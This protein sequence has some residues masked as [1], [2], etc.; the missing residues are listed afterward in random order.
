MGGVRFAY[1]YGYCGTAARLGLDSFGNEMLILAFIGL[2]ILDTM[3][4]LLFL[5]HGVAEG[6]PLIRAMLSLSGNP[7]MALSL[8]KVAGSAV[9]L[10]CWCGGRRRVLARVNLFYALVV[11]WNV[12]AIGLAR[13]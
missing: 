13:W 7:L 4:T 9:A 11:A 12:I 8:P 10:F 2:Q 3:T 6:N 5:R 1:Q